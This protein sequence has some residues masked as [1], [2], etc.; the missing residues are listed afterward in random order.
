MDHQLMAFAKAIVADAIEAGKASKLDSIQLLKSKL[1][2]PYAGREVEARHWLYQEG[3]IEKIGS[4]EYD[5]VTRVAF[6]YI[7]SEGDNYFK[8]ARALLDSDQASLNTLEHDDFPG[9]LSDNPTNNS[10]ENEG[11]IQDNVNRK[12]SYGK[13][14]TTQ[15][16]VNM[17]DE[18]VELIDSLGR[19]GYGKEGSRAA[20]IRQAILDINRIYH[21][22]RFSDINNLP[23][24]IIDMITYSSSSKIE[25][26]HIKDV[27]CSSHNIRLESIPNTV[28]IDKVK[29]IKGSIQAAINHNQPTNILCDATGDSDIVNKLDSLIE[30]VS[31]AYKGQ[32]SKSDF[33]FTRYL[34]V[35]D[36]DYE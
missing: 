25:H 6:N 5:R 19:L 2:K 13:N 24:D 9:I 15:V 23:R 26:E 31:M 17:S 7:K 1:P 30:G 29:D 4:S 10:Q 32:I 14:R 18:E 22:G 11:A 27:D 21:E 34:L 8:K 20:T 16:K 35:P 3:F 12:R 33:V 36:K 28:F